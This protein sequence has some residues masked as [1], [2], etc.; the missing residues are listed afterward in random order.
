MRDVGDNLDLRGVSVEIG[1]AWF[2]RARQNVLLS[3]DDALSIA[4]GTGGEGD[5]VILVVLPM[6]A[7]YSL[8]KA[9]YSVS[10]C[11]LCFRKA[12]TL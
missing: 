3:S 11:F 9:D 4:A 10:L 12:L 6:I 8:I 2:V 7:L 1:E 5:E